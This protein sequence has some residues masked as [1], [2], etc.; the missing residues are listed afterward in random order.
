[1]PTA[2]ARDGRRPAPDPTDGVPPLTRQTALPPLTRTE[3]HPGPHRDAPRRTR[4]RFAR[5]SRLTLIARRRGPVRDR[6]WGP[7]RCPVPWG[8]ATGGRWART[9]PATRGPRGASRTVR[10]ARRAG[11]RP[12]PARPPRLRPSSTRRARPRGAGRG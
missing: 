4:A 12:P 11:G 1:M 7:A 10:R 2:R 6:P 5:S 3:T 9:L 8:G